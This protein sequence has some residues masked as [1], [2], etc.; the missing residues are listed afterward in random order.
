M[1]R[2]IIGM[3]WMDGRL[4]AP[5]VCR[6]RGGGRARSALCSLHRVHATGGCVTPAVLLAG[7][8]AYPH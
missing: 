8:Y 5:H 6:L 4:E 3:E 1:I 2:S 7:Y